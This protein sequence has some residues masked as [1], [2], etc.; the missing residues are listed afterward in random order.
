MS[1]NQVC[2]RRNNFLTALGLGRRKVPVKDGRSRPAPHGGE[3]WT[4]PTTPSSLGTPPVLGLSCWKVNI[5]FSTELRALTE[6]KPKALRKNSFTTQGSEI[7]HSK[8]TTS[9]K[10]QTK[11]QKKN[12]KNLNR[13]FYKEYFQITNKN[14]KRYSKALVVKKM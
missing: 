8:T 9:Q 1:T 6:A 3:R 14:M 11:R 5:K 10:L 2:R 13:Y 4:S 12:I 7:S